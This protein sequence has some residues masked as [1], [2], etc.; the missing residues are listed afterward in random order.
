MHP[1]QNGTQVPDMPDAPNPIGDAGYMTEEGNPSVPGAHYFNAQIKEFENA[2]AAAGVTFD[3]TKFDHLAKV[4]EKGSEN[5]FKKHML[6]KGMPMSTVGP[7]PDPNIW[8]PAGRV[9]LLR[10]DY[11]TVFEIVSASAF[12]TDQATINANPRAYA[13]YW[14]DGDGATTFTTDDWALMMN[15]KVAGGYGAA[16]S[17]K[18]DHLQNITGSI[19]TG[20][21]GKHVSNFVSS[22]SIGAIFSTDD[23]SPAANTSVEAS[24]P[25]RSATINFDASRAVR[26]DTYTDSMG[27]FLD[28]CRVIPKG[29][30]SYA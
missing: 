26:T 11:P 25:N 20:D 30:F 16:G 18:E 7:N 6:F 3:R 15:I 8:L 4:F 21:R 28:H 13:G 5:F 24:S 2:L 14:G 9:E 10:A 27:L 17:S 12:L 29:V 23:N 1:L 19:S 22:T